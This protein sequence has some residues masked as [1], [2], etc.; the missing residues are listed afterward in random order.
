M[1]ELPAFGQQ[2]H[3]SLRATATDTVMLEGLQEAQWL[4]SKPPGR[5][6]ESE[7]AHRADCAFFFLFF[8]Q[9]GHQRTFGKTLNLECQCFP[10]LDIWMCWE[11]NVLHLPGKILLISALLDFTTRC[12]LNILQFN[13]GIPLSPVSLTGSHL[14]SVDASPTPLHFLFLFSLPEQTRAE[15]AYSSEKTSLL[16]QQCLQHPCIPSHCAP[17]GWERA[18]NQTSPAKRRSTALIAK[19]K[20]WDQAS[21]ST[22]RG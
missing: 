13:Y 3:S 4:S 11:K 14:L 18:K 8:R 15:L 17:G 21:F 20:G 9:L 7:E 1:A 19:G 10:A 6:R 2:C 12:Y 5:W 22:E 16:W